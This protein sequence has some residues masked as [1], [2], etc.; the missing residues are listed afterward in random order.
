MRLVVLGG[1]GSLGRAVVQAAAAEELDVVSVSRKPPSS[2]PPGATHREADV[3]TGT[4]LAEA[5]AGADAVVEATNAQSGAE[6]VLV[7]GT[8]RLL[9]A[10]RDAKVGHFVGISIVGIDD[11]PLDYYRVKVAQERVVGEGI[12][13][14]SLLRATQF[15][16]LIPRMARGAL[17][18]VFAP[19]RAK[20]QP[21]DVR[22]VASVVLDAVRAGPAGRLADVGGPEILELAE[23]MRA[24]ALAENEGRVVVAVPLPGAF[25]RFL[26]A[27]GLCT[28]DRAVGKITFAQWLGE[29]FRARKPA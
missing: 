20:V 23:L 4:G 29:R 12:A 5:L 22:D 2:L 24:W 3:T 11:A 14:W 13:P 1:T 16:D 18:V 9:E 10:A 28:P 26:R 27:G 15:H 8:R 17:G 25:G 19:R 21:I 6:K 7:E